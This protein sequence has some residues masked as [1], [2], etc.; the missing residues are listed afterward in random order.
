M[1]PKRKSWVELLLEGILELRH[2]VLVLRAKLHGATMKK[3]DVR[4][5]TN[6]HSNINDVK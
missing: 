4:N 3:E 2:I 5:Q 6:T 1:K